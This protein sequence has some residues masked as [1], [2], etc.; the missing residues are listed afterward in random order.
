MIHVKKLEE[1]VSGDRDLLASLVELFDA[2]LPSLL[3]KIESGL[4]N[5]SFEDVQYAAHRLK[6]QLR[7]F[8]EDELTVKLEAIES[9]GKNTDRKRAEALF[10]EVRDGLP[11]VRKELEQI[12]QKG[13]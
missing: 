6:G 5:E 2:D 3:L 10:A 12:I 11:E 8:F 9:F 7:N 1:L 4:K 13:F